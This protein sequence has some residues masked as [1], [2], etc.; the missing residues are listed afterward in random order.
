MLMK[1]VR[2]GEPSIANVTLVFLVIVGMGCRMI[3]MLLIPI[4]GVEILVAWIAVCHFADL[5]MVF[6]EKKRRG[7]EKI[8]LQ[9]DKRTNESRRREPPQ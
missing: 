9:E 8:E 7:Q 3:D 6:G 1:G 4:H 2:A 5:V